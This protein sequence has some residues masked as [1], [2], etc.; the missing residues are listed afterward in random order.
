MD[1]NMLHQNFLKAVDIINN[2]KN[3]PT[4]NELLKLYGLFK[5]A[6]IGDNNSPEPGY[7]DI[8]GRL[9]WNSWSSNIGKTKE[10]AKNEYINYVMELFAKYN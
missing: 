10:N 6:N 1:T 3:R 2:L 5:Q 7:I 9:K 4:D 8:K